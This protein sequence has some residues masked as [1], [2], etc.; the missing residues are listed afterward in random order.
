[1]HAGV[2]RGFDSEKGL[3]GISAYINTHFSKRR[4]LCM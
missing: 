1:M 4:N 3:S 2:H